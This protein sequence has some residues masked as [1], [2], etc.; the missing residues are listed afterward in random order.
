[1]AAVTQN[2]KAIENVIGNQRQIYYNLTFTTGQ[3]LATP[4]R[5]ILSLVCDP[6]SS[7][8]AVTYSSTLPITVTFTGSGTAS[9]VA[10]TG[11]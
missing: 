2:S 3:T 7:L 11:H 9:K 4:L 6:N 10:I 8:T 5:S 1:M